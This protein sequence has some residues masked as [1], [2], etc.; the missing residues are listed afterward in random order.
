MRI[1]AVTLGLFL[2]V[3]QVL[4]VPQIPVVPQIPL[5]SQIPVESFADWLAGVRTEAL[6]R[7]I[8]QS[9]VDAALTGIEPLPI[10]VQRDRTQAELMMSLDEYLESHL[11]KK[12]VRTAQEMARTHRALLASIE[13]KYGVPP[14]IVIAVWGIE[15]NFGRFSG[16]R[17]T[18]A[19]LA[20]LAY[21]PRRSTM[22]RAELFD[23]LEILDKGDIEPD[24]MLGS[25]AG[26]LGQ[27]QFMPSSFLQYAQDFD[28]DG[29]RDIWNSIPDVFA[30]I[31]NY[32]AAHGWRRGQTW[33]REVRVPKGLTDRLASLAPLQSSGCLAER[34]MTEPLPLSRWR[35]LGVKTIGGGRLP[36][37]KFDASLISGIHRHF[38]VYPNY[39]AVLQYNC[40]N[41]YGLTVGLLADAA[42][43][44]AHARPAKRAKAHVRHR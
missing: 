25:W 26:A 12:V 3:Q 18:I 32:L 17:P 11:T 6:Q 41:A 23:A 9:T 13:S 35:R 21:D 43:R 7:G 1:A 27:P 4:P 33:G 42:Q 15:S 5:V 22:F 29:K 38:L 40:V 36:S 30:S 31:A 16:S 44:A 8:S 37:G 34:R 24:R 10:V 2:F 20:T 14:G 19:A 39:Q 28:G